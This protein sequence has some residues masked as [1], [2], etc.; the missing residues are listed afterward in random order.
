M[1]VA[2]VAL[3][4]NI[5]HAQPFAKNSNPKLGSIVAET[6]DGKWWLQY[7]AKISE[8]FHVKSFFS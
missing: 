8:T 7:V 1:M 2:G 6:E 3:A 4:M 5:Q